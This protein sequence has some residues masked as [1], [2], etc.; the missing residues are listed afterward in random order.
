MN[1]DDTTAGAPAAEK[2]TPPEGFRYLDDAVGGD[3]V[4]VGPLGGP[5]PK[6]GDQLRGEA[7]LK[8]REEET[9][10]DKLADEAQ[11]KRDA[12]AAAQQPRDNPLS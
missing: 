11:A 9:A 3:L 1:M 10:L 12:E 5:A 4:P 7:R 2:P 8:E 6:S